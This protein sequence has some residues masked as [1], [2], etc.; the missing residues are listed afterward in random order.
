MIV[1]I[2]ISKQ[3]IDAAWQQNGQLQQQRFDYNETGITQLLTR[4]NLI[5]HYVMEATGTYH[6]RLALAL[7]QAER[8]VSVVNPLIIKRFAQMQLSRV[9]SDRADA[10]LIR[11]YAEQQTLTPWAPAATEVLELQQAH[12]WLNDLIGERTRLTN[13]K[14]AHIHHAS[15]SAFVLAQM[16]EQAQ[17]LEHR[18]RTCEAHLEQLVKKSFALLFERLQ[19]IPAIGIKTAIELIIVTGAFRQF[20][21][22]KAL[23]AYVGVSPTT[24]CSGSSV[25]GRGGIAKL[26]QGRM[27]QLLYLCSWTAKSCNPACRALYLRLKA[28]GKP[29]KVINI[30]IAHKLLRQ[31]YAVA[32]SQKAFSPEF[33]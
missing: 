32:T 19:T 25:K 24:Y 18:I 9:K 26:G 22:I 1:G 21:D 5:A 16:D 8:K 3:W 2:D 7:H 6:T 17:L 23:S 14:E 20:A 29:A 11:R 15:P 13:R 30:A 28:I 27:R 4:T 10:D 31:A 33:T 12:G